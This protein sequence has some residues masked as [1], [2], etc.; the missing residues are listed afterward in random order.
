MARD[1]LVWEI[2]RLGGRATIISSNIPLRQ[3]G[4]PYASA[5]EPDEPGVA[6]YFSYRDAP[7]CFACDQ[8]DRV[9]DNLQA[10][11]K[12]IEALRGIARWGSGDMILAVPRMPTQPRCSALTAKR[13]DAPTRISPA[14][15]PRRSGGCNGRGSRRSDS[16]PIGW[17]G[18]RRFAQA[19]AMMYNN[20]MAKPPT[21]FKRRNPY[22]VPAFARNGGA[23]GKT[24]KAERR[25][26]RVRDQRGW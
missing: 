21:L 24:R 11:R 15:V 12:T 18:L 10:T 6:V 22:A 4:L 23:H 2:E 13:P 20:G 8:W 7:R 9:R 17:F 1:E 3:D 19:F 14:V 26:T 5:K 25:A 16:G